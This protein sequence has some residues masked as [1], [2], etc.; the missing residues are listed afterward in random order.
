MDRRICLLTGGNAGIGRAAARQLAARGAHVVIAARNPDRGRQT[1]EAIRREVPG[2]EVE[3]LTM[4]LSSAASIAAGCAAWR[5]AGHRRL[6]VLI[7]NAAE[8]DVGRRTPVYTADGIESVWATNHLGPVRLTHDLAP[9]L[10][11]SDQARIITVAS[12]GLVLYPRLQVDLDDPEFR[13]RPFSVQAAYY[14]SKLAQV[15]YTRWLA[16]HYRGTPITANCVRVTNVRIDVDRYPDLRPWQRRLYAIKSRFSITPDTM[17]ETY[18][19]LALDPALVGTS[20][21][22][23]D[24]RRRSVR[25]NAW[26]R[27]PRH[28][29]A[30]MALTASYVPGLEVPESAAA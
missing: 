27:D 14:Q 8:F 30:V 10:A 5:A 12:Q 24:E 11:A 25:P 20:G 29:Q 6:D 28:V 16:E 2:A 7:H 17:A 26:A 15:M 1:V 4:D 22:Y 13:R 21:G 3:A 23:V 18:V 9:E 19:S